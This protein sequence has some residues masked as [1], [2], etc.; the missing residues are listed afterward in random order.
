MT[1]TCCQNKQI[2][3]YDGYT[4]CRA[5]FLLAKKSDSLKCDC[6]GQQDAGTFYIKPLEAKFAFC[7]VCFLRLEEIT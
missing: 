5:C 7:L 1:K 4:V 6:C 3:C 2:L